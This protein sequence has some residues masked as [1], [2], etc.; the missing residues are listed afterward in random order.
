MRFIHTSDWQIGQVFR[1]VDADLQGVLRQ[2]RIDAID[3]IGALAMAEGVAT[4]LVAGDVYDFE[5]LADETLDRPIRRMAATPGVAWHLLP[6]N[7]DPH[8]PRGVWE[9]V[10]R[11]GL[12]VNVHVHLEAAP[13]ELASDGGARAFVLPAPLDRP[14]SVID[15]TAWMDAAV[16]PEGALRIGLAHGSVVDFGGEARNNPVDPRRTDSA[17]LDYLALGDWHGTKRIGPRAWYS[18]TPEPTKFDEIDNGQVLLVDLP[19]PGA[20]PAVDTRR[21][22]VH[23]WRRMRA[24]LDG[25]GDIEGLAAVARGSG[26]DRVLLELAVEGA[27]SLAGRARLETET[28]AALR[29]E[30][31]HLRVSLDGLA[32]SPTLDDLDRID[33]AGFVRVA[34]ERLKAAMDDPADPRRAVARDA[35]QRLFL[36][37]A[38]LRGE[39]GEEGGR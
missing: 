1:Y 5:E 9:R 27:V 33:R 2:A 37:L 22:A 23:E 29:A 3:R 4:V 28:L 8:R 10:M 14:R 35:L 25:D 30:A 21:V 38:R 32:A 17:R 18:G 36:E 26:L 34:A 19:A 20:P 24:R 39:A 7:H 31:R 11:H 12:P 16:T 6:G 13:V 15:R